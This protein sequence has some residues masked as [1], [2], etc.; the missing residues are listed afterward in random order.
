MKKE[1]IQFRSPVFKTAFSV[2]LGYT[3]SDVIDFCQ[4]VNDDPRLE[5][6]RND[7]AEALTLTWD[8]SVVVWF[9]GN[10]IDYGTVIHELTH[11]VMYMLSNAGVPIS[12]ENEESMAYN[13]GWAVRECVSKIPKK[14]L[15]FD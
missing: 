7:S 13:M 6:I 15:T 10:K 8:N 1:C 14:L 2:Y 9:S 3:L 12:I 4:V 5:E 11:A